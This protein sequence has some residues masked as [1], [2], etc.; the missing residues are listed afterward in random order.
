M[1]KNHKQKT[2]NEV[3][4]EAR[5]ATISNIVEML[6]KMTN[7]VT[8]TYGDEELVISGPSRTMRFKLDYGSDQI[9]YMYNE[10][11]H[12]VLPVGGCTVKEYF[13]KYSDILHR[14]LKYVEDT[15]LTKDDVFNYRVDW[16]KWH[17][18]VD[19]ALSAFSFDDAAEVCNKLGLVEEEAE[20]D[21]Y[22]VRPGELCRTV[23]SIMTTLI[24]LYEMAWDG[25]PVGES[26]YGYKIYEN[27]SAMID[28]RGTLC[29]SL[30][31]KQ[32]DTEYIFTPQIVISLY[33]DTD[34]VMC[35]RIDLVPV[36]QFY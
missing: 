18:I 5:P 4:L 11:L 25:S 15:G 34:G 22:K 7:S 29:A 3:P 9:Y 28:E 21:P 1:K 23:S 2:T 19:D 17:D 32:T 26:N 6:G 16:N 12:G 8:F 13:D 14:I 30:N 27:C 20:T 36:G 31:F 35:F 33:K 24:K 10:S